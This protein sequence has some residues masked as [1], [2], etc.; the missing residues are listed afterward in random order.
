MA[1]SE[2][3]APDLFHH[4]QLP[5]PA[6]HI[7]LLQIKH[8]SEAPDLSLGDCV[9]LECELTT[10]P[11]SKSPVYRA[12]SYTWG[13]PEDTA[14]IR[15]SGKK[16][17]VR[18]NCQYALRQVHK[19]CEAKTYIWIDSICIQQND[20]DEK[21]H[22]VAMV[23]TI[24]QRAEVVLACIGAHDEHSRFLSRILT[25]NSDLFTQ[26]SEHCN[27]ELFANNQTRPLNRNLLVK[28]NRRFSL[29]LDWRLR[30][31]Q[32][33]Q[34]PK[35]L[36]RALY[37]VLFRPYFQRAW[38]WP[39]LR[40]AR[41]VEILCG[42]DHINVSSLFGLSLVVT[43]GS[44]KVQHSA[45]PYAAYI[46]TLG[47]W[48]FPKYVKLT[49]GLSIYVSNLVRDTVLSRVCPLWQ[50]ALRMWAED[51]YIGGGMESSV[52]S[53]YLIYFDTKTCHLQHEHLRAMVTDQSMR[54]PLWHLLNATFKLRSEKSRDRIYAVLP[55]VNWSCETMEPIQPDYSADL[56]DVTKTI[57]QHS[58]MAN[59]HPFNATF[60]LIRHS[61]DIVKAME[62]D[63][64]TSPKFAQAMECRRHANTKINTNPQSGIT[65]VP[66][67]HFR[68]FR[69]IDNEGVFSL[70]FPPYEKDWHKDCRPDDCYLAANAS[71]PNLSA[72]ERERH[73]KMIEALTQVP[74]ALRPKLIISRHEHLSA[75]LP[76]D[77]QDGDWI[78]LSNGGYPAKALV[79]REETQTHFRIVG[80]MIFNHST[81]S[82]RICL[83]A[84]ATT[85]LVHFD[86]EDFIVLCRRE[87]KHMWEYGRNIEMCLDLLSNRVCSAPGSSYA[88][89][90]TQPEKR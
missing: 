70:E 9:D 85:F 80:E 32:L 48:T 53:S 15:V 44:D 31:W 1:S 54:E 38:T 86:I 60:L 47:R 28:C 24:F 41:K 27:T 39:E 20:N 64:Q 4:E 75:V 42:G 2:V 6:N 61:L 87:T 83:R 77:A 72:P 90:E 22:Q 43:R 79:V 78:I 40:L 13:D 30:K 12:I 69:V 89:F 73:R 11:T 67:I 63:T 71:P 46:C 45:I 21:S 19:H 29:L 10:W 7:R 5:D 37:A 36:I 33:G 23:G 76:H 3:T 58:Y 84:G 26:A 16:M 59:D 74:A 81:L 51:V 68:G 34:D 25:R 14:W 56:L 62:L 17:Q 52:E 66:P 8:V 55:I 18:Q 82:P 50:T 57:L 65:Q 49:T 35:K 88:S